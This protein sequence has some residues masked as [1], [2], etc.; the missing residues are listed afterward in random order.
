MYIENALPI[1]DCQDFP[2]LVIHSIEQT[3]VR[4]YYVRGSRLSREMISYV[5]YFQCNA[6][7][8]NPVWL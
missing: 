3:L 6:N 7:L 8:Q 4:V 1:K 2:I 5:I